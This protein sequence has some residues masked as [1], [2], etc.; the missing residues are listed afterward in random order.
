MPLLYGEGQKSFIRLQEEI[1]KVYDDQSIFAW[2]LNRFGKTLYWDCTSSFK[3][4]GSGP[5][6]Q[7]AFSF[8]IVPLLATSPAFFENSSNIIPSKPAKINMGAPH[9]MTNRGLRIDIHFLKN[10]IELLDPASKTSV[11]DKSVSYVALGCVE[12]ENPYNPLTMA[13]TQVERNIYAR[14][15]AV[16]LVAAAVAWLEYADPALRS[17]YLQQQAQPYTSIPGKNLSKTSCLLLRTLPAHFGP[18]HDAYPPGCWDQKRGIITLSQEPKG[19]TLIFPLTNHNAKGIA[20]AIRDGDTMSWHGN[21]EMVELPISAEKQPLARKI[22][23]HLEQEAEHE[24]YIA[25]EIYSIR[26]IEDL[27]LGGVHRLNIKD[28]AKTKLKAS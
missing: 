17:I 13:V 28:I 21:L 23:M 3:E 6:E 15:V 24:I 11:W 8:R 9:V 25:D 12:E 7:E 26:L 18:I 16:Y 22:D 1:M 4:F 27:V 2:G 19:I 10:N 5:D 20:L 14:V